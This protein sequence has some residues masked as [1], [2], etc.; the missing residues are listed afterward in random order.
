MNWFKSLFLWL[1]SAHC[2]CG[3]EDREICRK[4]EYGRKDSAC[5]FCHHLPSCHLLNGVQQ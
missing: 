2:F 1:N 5:V 3:C 4:H